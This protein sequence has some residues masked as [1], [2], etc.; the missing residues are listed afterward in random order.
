MNPNSPTAVI[1]PHEKLLLAI[2]TFPWDATYR[3]LIGFFIVP[4]MSTMWPHTHLDWAVLPFLSGLL[5]LLRVVSAFLRRILPF[6]EAI[7][8]RW[9]DQRLIGKRF[10]SYQWQKLFGIGLGLA[11][12]TLWS[13]QFLTARIVVSLFCLLSGAVGLVI[14]R[15]IAARLKKS[16]SLVNHSPSVGAIPGL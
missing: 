10:D 6:S 8:R 12:Y 16:D 14:W 9:A 5:L 7:R 15:T 2:T 3:T 13:R 11:A 1:R 4:V